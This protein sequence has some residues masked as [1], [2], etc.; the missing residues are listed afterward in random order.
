M[1]SRSYL[2]SGAMQSMR[3]F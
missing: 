2:H 3:I 1:A